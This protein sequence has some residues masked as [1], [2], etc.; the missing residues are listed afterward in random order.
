MPILYNSKICCTKNKIVPV[1]KRGI[2]SIDD[3]LNLFGQMESREGMITKWG[4][5][6]NFLIYEQLR[7]RFHNFMRNLFFFLISQKKLFFIFLFFASHW[8]KYCRGDFQ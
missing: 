4:I 5:T 8:Y 3:L 6:C 1:F 2:T 7:F